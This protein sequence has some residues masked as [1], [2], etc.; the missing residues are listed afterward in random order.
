M[1]VVIKEVRDLTDE[2]FAK[3]RRLNFGY[4]GQMRDD[5]IDHRYKYF[6]KNKPAKA[7]MLVEGDKL[8][9]WSLVFP[10]YKTKGYAA[11]FYIRYSHRRRGY[12]T[13]LLQK[14]AEIDPRPLVFPHDSRSGGLLKKEPV[15]CHVS[16]RIWLR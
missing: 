7:I 5:L 16:E 4:K 9:G 12:G 10:I 3:C 1:K 15:R 8:I 2:E 6:N 14:V 13:L 11:H